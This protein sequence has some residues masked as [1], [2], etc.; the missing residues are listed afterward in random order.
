MLSTAKR[1]A[2]RRIGSNAF[3]ARA[4]RK[5]RLISP[6]IALRIDGI[7]CRLGVF[8]DPDRAWPSADKIGQA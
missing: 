7:V 1:I 6:R 3:I 4:G 5:S 8:E 2:R